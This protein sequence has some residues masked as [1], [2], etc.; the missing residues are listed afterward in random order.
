[1]SDQHLK[2]LYDGKNGKLMNIIT[3]KFIGNTTNNRYK[4][5]PLFTVLQ[6]KC[7][8][9]IELLNFPEGS[10]TINI[11][12]YNLPF[13]N[14][15]V[16]FKD[17][18]NSSFE[19]LKEEVNEKKCDYLNFRRI[20][21]VF[22]TWLNMSDLNRYRF[23]QDIYKFKITSISTDGIINT[24]T[25]ILHPRRLFRLN[26]SMPVDFI[27]CELKNAKLLVEHTQIESNNG[28]W[29]IQQIKQKNKELS[30]IDKEKNIN[31]RVEMYKKESEYYIPGLIDKTI[32][33]S[34]YSAIHLVLDK[35][36]DNAFWIKS[37][38]YNILLKYDGQLTDVWRYST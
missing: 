24:S 36:V 32:N 11:Q 14:N 31:S 19:L 26:L 28:V 23:N 34:R 8:K 30:D 35:D 18:F 13:I 27:E 29:D 5:L 12:G 33:A 21:D 7:V 6:D 38:H 22:I 20:N 9:S 37:S 2:E 25:E 15:T 10:Y 17:T 4:T 16:D 3:H 1:M